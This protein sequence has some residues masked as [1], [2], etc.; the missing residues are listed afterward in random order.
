MQVNKKPVETAGQ[1]Q[2]TGIK[3][4]EKVR[5]GDEVYQF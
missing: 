3:V 2:S 5:V 1:D 4:G